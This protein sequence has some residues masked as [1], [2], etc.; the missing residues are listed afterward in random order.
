[1][2]LDLG[3]TKK[4]GDIPAGISELI[5][6][7]IKDPAY[8]ASISIST[9]VR[10]M[11]ILDMFE[12]IA[13]EGLKE[14]RGWVLKN[15]LVKFDTIGEMKKLAGTDQALIDALQLM[16]TEG[17]KISG[18]WLLNEAERIQDLVDKYRV[19]IIGS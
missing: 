7:E 15:T 6:G 11:A 4:R 18:H 8:L 16:D 1:M 13:T 19:Q 3:Y 9:P 5:L 17:V 12:V 10:D 14:N 2:K